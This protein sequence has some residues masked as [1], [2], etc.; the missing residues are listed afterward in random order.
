VF[1]SRVTSDLSPNRLSAAVAR[2][3][4]AH[5]EFDDLTESNPT[6]VGLRYP[7]RLLDALAAPAA[8][9]Y[10]PQPFGTAQA[11]DAVAGDFRRR[12][13]RVARDRIVLTASTSEAYSLLFKLLCDPG[14]EVLVPVPSYPLFEYLA[15]LDSVQARPYRLE[16]HGAWSVDLDGLR[17]STTGR[18]RAVVVVNPNNPTGSYLKRAELDALA[19]HC[20]ARGLA[21]IGDEVFSEYVLDAELPRTSSVLAQR[22]ALTFGLGGL[23]KGLGLPQLK[24]GWMV[25]AGPDALARPALQRLELICD[26]YLS[27]ATPVQEGLPSLLADGATVRTQIRDRVTRNYRALLAAA[28]RCPSVTV[29]PAEGGWY[30]VLQVPAMQSEESLVLQILEHERVLVHPGYFFDFPRE[31]FL[32]LS[33]LPRP[34]AFDRAVARVFARVEAAA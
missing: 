23:S 9:G 27:V 34:E 29:L 14:D 24:L 17:Q 13:M 18:T 25:V 32:V 8:L 19:T 22:Q 11:R 1:S 5:V 26:T 31:A 6:R 12:G 21:L 28:A 4:S 16:Y 15:A 20:R 3:R 2:L 7:P 33:L 10:D 30:A